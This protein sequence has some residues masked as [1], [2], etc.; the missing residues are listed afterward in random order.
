MPTTRKPAQVIGDDPDPVAADAPSVFDQPAGDEFAIDLSTAPK[1]KRVDA[2]AALLQQAPKTMVSDLAPAPQPRI[3]PA[4]TGVTVEW[5]GGTRRVLVWS[6][7][8]SRMDPLEP[9][10]DTPQVRRTARRGDIAVVPDDARTAMDL[11][12][13]YIIDQP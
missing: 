10:G 8:Y 2:L 12:Y 3:I 5:Q 6:H 1:D 13:G 11:G 9:A 7:N 4:A